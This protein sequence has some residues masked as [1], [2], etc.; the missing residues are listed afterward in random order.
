MKHIKVII[1]FLVVSARVYSQNLDSLQKK[2]A[3]NVCSCIGHVDKYSKLKPLIDKCYENKMNF[4]FNDATPQEIKFYSNPSNLNLV[5]Q[6]LEYYLKST[7][8]DVVR[9]IKEYVTPY[10]N[11]NNYPTNFNQETLKK[12]KE[13]L[14]SYN[15]RTIAFDAEIVKLNKSDPKKIFLKVKFQ[16]G[17]I[18]WVGDMAN[19]DFEVVGNNVRFLGYFIMAEKNSD[20]EYN[21][22]GYLVI[23]FGSVELTSNKLAMYPGSEKQI[24]AWVNGKI[25]ESK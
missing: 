16:D 17:Q 2:F 4:I 3:N 12:A 23:S 24:H 7:C 19:S 20:E 21:K 18:M 15:G 11:E 6:K 13:D 5:S 14:I 8:P 9:V 10:T 25:P 22:L 1:L